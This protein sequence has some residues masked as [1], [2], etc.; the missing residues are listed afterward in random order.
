MNYVGRRLWCLTLLSTMFHLFH[1]GLFYWWRKPEHLEK[2]TDLSQFTFSDN[3]VSS[4]PRHEN[5]Q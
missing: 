4:T 3:V 5:K 2:T 1:D